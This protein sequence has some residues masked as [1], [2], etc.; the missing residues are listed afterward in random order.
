MRKVKGI[1]ILLMAICM[2]FAMSI[3]AFAAKETNTLPDYTQKGSIVVDIL[4]T[5]TGKAISGGTLTLYEIAASK[6]VNGE[7]LFE[8]IDVFKESNV[9][10]TAIQESDAGEKELASKLESYVNNNRITGK[11]VTVD[12]NG[13]AEW[14]DLELG[15]YLVVHTNSTEGYSPVNTFLVTVPRYLNGTY[16]YNVE[17]SPKTGTSDTVVQEALEPT[18]ESSADNKKL[19]KTGQVWW[20]I[21][22]LAFAGVL[23]VMFGWYRRRC[24]ERSNGV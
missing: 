4:S 10:L 5:D 2:M 15:L 1:K 16:V 9:D 22:I 19:P 11:S 6:Q 20:P 3:T 17:A 7:N 14:T 23:C 13:Q 18:M 21:P 8:L 24:F 12:E